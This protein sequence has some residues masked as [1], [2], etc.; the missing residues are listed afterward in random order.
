MNAEISDQVQTLEKAVKALQDKIEQQIPVYRS[1]P[2]AQEATTMQ[3]EKIL[4]NN[5]AMQEFRGTVRDYAAS[6][7]CLQSILENTDDGEDKTTDLD[8]FRSRFRAA[9]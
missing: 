4:K 2:L 6:L 1:L 8:D 5:P 3:G 9:Q 7:K